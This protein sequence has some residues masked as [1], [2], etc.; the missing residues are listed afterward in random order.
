MLQ[1]LSI[2]N[3]VIVDTLDLEFE[4]GF[5]TLTGET[6][7]GKS[8]LIDALSLS[9]GARNEGSVTRNGTDKAEISTVFDVSKNVAVQDW[10]AEQEIDETEQL[11]LRRVIYADGRSRAFINGVASTVTQL[12]ALGEHLIDIYSQNAHHSLMLAATQ[13]EILDDFAGNAQLCKHVADSFATWTTLNKQCIDIEKHAA[14]YAAEL[15]ELAEQ[16][17]ELS[18]LGFNL[19]EWTELQQEH[20]RLANG[21]SLLTGLEASV[22]MLDDGDLN[23]HAL[24]TQVQVQLND[25]VTY[26]ATLKEAADG[27]SSALIQIEDATRELNRYLQK[28]DLDPARLA[29]VEL[30]MQAVHHLARKYRIK[31]EELAVLLAEKETRM[32]TLSA[33]T[34]DGTLKKQ[35]AE[36]LKI[37]EDAAAKLSLARA[38]AAKTLS[39]N[40]TAQMQALSLSGGQFVV[41][42]S[43]QDGNAFGKEAIDFLVAGH[44]G[45][46]PKP[47]NK[48]ASGGELS[49]ISLALHVTTAS[50]GLVPCMIFDEVDVGIGGGVAEVV[51]KLLHELGQ[52]RQVLVITHLAQV[53]SQAQQHLQV[54]KTQTDGVTLSHIHQLSQAAR[55]EEVARMM[56]GLEITEATL[57]HAKEMLGLNS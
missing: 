34:D 22:A 13:R 12:K 6:G 9:L 7:A 57:N 33:F 51:G 35:T 37:Y 1:S 21:A 11:I 19:D 47:L 48:V 14:A 16:T 56:G 27:V 36:A 55:I 39:H 30:R 45:V 3:F 44:A 2:R 23:I 18:A 8:I 10:L 53:A 41:S 24:L 26:D 46:D 49:R 5:T 50:K 54:T 31:P 42:L 40:I 43:P 17:D 4:R 28:A 29:E 32:K 52:K 25:L 38:A 15:T 20:H